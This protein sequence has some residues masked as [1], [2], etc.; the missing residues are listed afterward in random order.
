MTAAEAAPMGTEPPPVRRRRGDR[1][2][3]KTAWNETGRSDGEAAADL[4]VGVIIGR[5]DHLLLSTWFLDEL[6]DLFGL[7]EEHAMAL[8]GETMAAV[9]PDLYAED[10]ATTAAIAMAKAAPK[11]PTPGSTLPRTPAMRMIVPPTPSHV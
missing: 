3:V 4:A 2:R 8:A 11:T 9:L 6:A 5:L 1:V 10:V 7:T